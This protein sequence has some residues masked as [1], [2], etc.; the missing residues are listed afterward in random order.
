MRALSEY[1]EM[2]LLETLREALGGT[3]SV[4]VGGQVTKLPRPEY[5]V[6]LQFG[7]APSR[8]DSLFRAVLS[9]IDSVKAGAI[10]DADV[11]KIREQHLRTLEANGQE[12][13]YWLS[14]LA[15][16]LENG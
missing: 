2:R 4:S 16:R 7:S 11:Q 10:A 15:A 3:Y 13:S 8:A 14:N 9:V 6:S 5:S 1:L 12:N